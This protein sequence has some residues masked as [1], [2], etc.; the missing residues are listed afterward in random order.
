[1]MTRTGFSRRNPIRQTGKSIALPSEGGERHANLDGPTRA[2]GQR[3][4]K[5]LVILVSESE[6]GH[7]SAAGRRRASGEPDFP[8]PG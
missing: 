8:S 4:A 7:A 6:S 3:V 5:S 2:R 1:M